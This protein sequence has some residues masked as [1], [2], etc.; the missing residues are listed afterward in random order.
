[1]SWNSWEVDEGKER[2]WSGV[3]N[4]WIKLDLERAF[5]LLTL[6]IN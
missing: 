6:K 4:V 3:E 2:D 5:R 1:M